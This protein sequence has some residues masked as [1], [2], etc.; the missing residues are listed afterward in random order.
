MGSC[1]RPRQS[2]AAP[3][4]NSR[5][6]SIEQFQAPDVS[7]LLLAA[8]ALAGIRL[9]LRAVIATV[10]GTGAM[11]R[12]NLFRLVQSRPHFPGVGN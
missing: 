3:G 1:R 6:P 12:V 2:S 4:A 10:L 8:G 5:Q 9:A 11:S 7:W